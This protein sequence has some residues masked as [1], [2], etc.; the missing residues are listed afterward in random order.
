MFDSLDSEQASE[1]KKHLLI[2]L[3]REGEISGM[4]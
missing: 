4:V 1:L 2:L 3:G